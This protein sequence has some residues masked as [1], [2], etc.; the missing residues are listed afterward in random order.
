MPRNYGTS[1]SP[2]RARIVLARCHL[3]LEAV[4][5]YMK[6]EGVDYREARTM[7]RAARRAVPERD[8]EAWRRRLLVGGSYS[9]E[10][11]Q[12]K[13]LLGNAE[14]ALSADNFHTGEPEWRTGMTHERRDLRAAVALIRRA[15]EELAD[16]IAEAR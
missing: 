6:G 16:R 13:W 9:L 3:A 12:L 14:N 5:L 7:L 11:E 1:R 15:T 4:R 8:S 2:K 10:Y